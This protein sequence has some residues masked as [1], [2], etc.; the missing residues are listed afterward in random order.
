MALTKKI[1]PPKNVK[2]SIT[3]FQ[4]TSDNKY[5]IDFSYIFPTRELMV[6]EIETGEYSFFNLGYCRLGF[7]LP[8]ETKSKYYVIASCAETI[9][10][11]DVTTKE[12]YELSYTSGKFKLQKLF[13]DNQADVL[14]TDYAS[15]IFA[16]SDYSNKIKFFDINK[17][18]QEVLE[19]HRGG[20]LYD[21]KLSKNGRFVALAESRNVY[22]FDI[23]RKECIKYYEVEYGC[24][25]DF[26]DDD[27]KLLIGTWEKGYC[28][29]I[30]EL[31]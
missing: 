15:N 7:I 2:S 20:V 14:V 17:N 3:D 30:S 16:I 4:I 28:L 5:I 9:D 27:T 8:T 24:F 22:I 19:Y 25:V 18:Y 21:L 29:D 31:G 26:L 13:I 11:P 12:L 1:P 6:I 23:I 10:A